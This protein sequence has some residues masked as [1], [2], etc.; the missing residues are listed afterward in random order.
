MSNH[1]SIPG[2]FA[3][4]NGPYG[5]ADLAGNVI[6]MTGDISQGTASQK[7]ADTGATIT[8]TNAPIVRWYKGGSWQGH[9]V[10]ASYTFIATNRYVAMG[11]RCAYDAGAPAASA[12]PSG[13]RGEYFSGT[14]LDAASSKGVRVDPYIAFNATTFKNPAATT[15]STPYSVRWTANL[16]PRYS[17]TYTFKTVSGDGIRLWVNG[18]QL[19]NDW[20]THAALTKTA[21]IALVAG[22]VTTIKVEHYNAGTGTSTKVLWSSPSQRE[23]VIPASQLT[24]VP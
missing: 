23:Q 2:H 7:N 10:G 24:P 5:H 22:Q 1:V 19:I 12:F 11:G 13:F 18:T 6:N 9:Q 4:G 21:T 15:A 14:A 17:Q 20:T 8:V 3:K 16:V